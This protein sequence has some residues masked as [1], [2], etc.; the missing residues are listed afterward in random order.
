[1]TMCPH[2]IK[3]RVIQ[4]RTTTH[5]EPNTILILSSQQTRKMLLVLFCLFLFDD[6]SNRRPAHRGCDS[7]HTALS[8]LQQETTL[9]YDV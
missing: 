6:A 5:H 3:E 7:S 2:V 4:N 8:Q 1:M 9:A